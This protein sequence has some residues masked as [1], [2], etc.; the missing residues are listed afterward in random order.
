MFLLWRYHVA[1]MDR[2]S[3]GSLGAEG[4][5]YLRISIATALEDLKLGVERIR[6]AATDLDGFQ[7]FIQEGKH[8]C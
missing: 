2:R 8:L 1:T 7:Q 3:F 4:Q 5:H 6:S